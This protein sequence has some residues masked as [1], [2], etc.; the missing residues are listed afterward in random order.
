[1]KFQIISKSQRFKELLLMTLVGNIPTIFFGVKLRNIL[2]RAIF[3]RIGRSV[4]IQD[5]VEFSGASSIEIGSGV[6]IFKGVYIDGRGYSNNKICLENGVVIERNVDIGAL[7]G[8]FI[9]IGQNTF[10]GPGSSIAGPGNIK[11]GQNCLI[12]AQSGIFANN[13]NFTDL[14]LPIREQGVT[15]QGIVIE[16]DCWL[17][18]GVKVL[19]GVTI[20]KGCVIGA[21]SVVTKDIPPF[22]VAVG[23]PARVIKKRGSKELINA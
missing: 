10:I 17:G 2:Y 7:D 9:H 23:I 14:E 5:N 11:I 22:S 15:R 1:M 3:A 18:S 13:H 21:N 4:F 12:A 16:D 8:T 20:G 19:D 6:Y